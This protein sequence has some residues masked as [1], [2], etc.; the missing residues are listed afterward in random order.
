[1]NC[2]VC[3]VEFNPVY[4]SLQ[5]GHWILWNNVNS[6]WKKNM[7]RPQTQ[8]PSFGGYWIISRFHLFFV[9]FP[10][11]FYRI[12][13]KFHTMHPNYPCFPFLQSLPSHPS[14]PPHT[15]TL[16]VL[17]VLPI[18]YSLEHGQSL[19]DNWVLSHPSPQ[20]KV[21]GCEELHFSIFITIFKD[22]PPPLPC[23]DIVCLFVFLL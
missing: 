14:T 20:P 23:L 13:W 8:Q 5:V 19:R 16:Q 1:M 9:S 22:S 10:T 3:Y 6:F 12:I 21:N 18:Y 7:W 2:E 11:H 15:Q 4:I 17:F